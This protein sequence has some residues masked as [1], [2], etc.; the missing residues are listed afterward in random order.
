VLSAIYGA[1]LLTGA[2]IMGRI[3]LK[4]AELEASIVMGAIGAPFFIY[5]ARRK[6][7]PS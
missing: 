1:L 3:L 5:L 2:D 4:P 7:L 6:S